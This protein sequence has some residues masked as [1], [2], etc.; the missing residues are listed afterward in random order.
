MHSHRTKELRYLSFFSTFY[1]KI[2]TLRAQNKQ[3]EI[4]KDCFIQQKR[5]Y[6]Y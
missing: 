6:L 3:K 4:R 2:Q 5:I 1:I